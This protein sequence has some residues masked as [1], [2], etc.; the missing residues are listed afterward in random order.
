M[1]NFVAKHAKRS[2]A[3]VHTQKQ[4]KHAPRCKHKHQLIKELK[5]GN[6]S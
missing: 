4:G 3:G 5:G 1:R 2:G 6:Y